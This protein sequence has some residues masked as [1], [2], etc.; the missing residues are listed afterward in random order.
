MP[1]FITLTCPACGGKLEITDD[2]E[3]FACAHCGRE[4]VVKRGGGIVS[5]APVVDAIR[6]VETGVD[7]T[8]SELAIARL[9]REIDDLENLSRG[10]RVSKGISPAGI[11]SNTLIVLGIL[12]VLFGRMI[13]R[14][15]F[16][17]CLLPE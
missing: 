3:R 4:H 14:A 1:D 2:I 13:Y 15:W 12:L 11:I 16:W 9:Q 10:L 7:K 8:A 6:N 5:L 17:P